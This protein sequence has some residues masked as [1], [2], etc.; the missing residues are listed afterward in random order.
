MSPEPLRVLVTGAT[1]GLGRAIVA[2]FTTAGARVGACDLDA[3]LARHPPR[4]AAATAAFDAR[5]PAGVAA[6][7]AA[8]AQGLGGLDAVVANAGVVDTIH[9]AARFPDEAWEGDLRT[10]LTGPFLLAKAAH[11]HLAA[12]ARASLTVVS[13]AS[14][15]TGLPG[16]AAYT[17]AKA[18]LLGLVRTLAAEWA[19]DGIRVNAVLP[20]MIGTPKVR[21]LPEPLLH[22]LLRTI[23]LR[24]IGEPDEVAGTIAFLAS[25]AAGYITGQ[26][27]RV[28]GGLG[29]STASLAPG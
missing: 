23:P 3:A 12:S 11:P 22:G 17:A 16:Q 8:V 4:D 18:G 9:R 21:A 2:A 14:A 28:D 6:G 1:G 27:L 26:A 19:P 24:R 5:D 7:V 10:N 29:R 13:S 25:P 15:E 20:G